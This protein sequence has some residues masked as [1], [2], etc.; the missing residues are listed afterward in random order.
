[1]L[2]A[3]VTN[4]VPIAVTGPRPESCPTR[5]GGLASAK[6]FW[7]DGTRRFGS[8]YRLW[9][10]A[11]FRHARRDVRECSWLRASLNNDAAFVC[12]QY[13]P[14]HLGPGSSMICTPVE[15]QP[16]PAFT[17]D[18]ALA[19]VC[20]SI[21]RVTKVVTLSASR[22]VVRGSFFE[23]RLKP[24]PCIAHAVEERCVQLDVQRIPKPRAQ[25]QRGLP[26]PCA[27][28]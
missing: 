7:T 27:C 8:Q 19:F 13:S 6:D 17:L 4:S 21:E 3:F 10:I 11:S 1:M 20:S 18:D 22:S 25:R 2:C 16:P 9:A 5:R 24:R 26:I 28:I 12:R 23:F 15:T 14:N